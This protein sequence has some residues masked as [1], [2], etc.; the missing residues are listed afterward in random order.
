VVRGEDR[1]SL[2]PLWQLLPL[3]FVALYLV[4]F[5]TPP[6]RTSAPAPATPASAARSA[7][8]HGRLV[9]LLVDSLRPSNVSDASLMPTLHALA[10]SPGTVALQVRTCAS[11]F[12]LPCIQTIFSGRE[13]PMSAGLEQFSAYAGGGGSFIG[14]AA[15]AGLGVAL[16]GNE[17]LTTLYGRQARF[18]S[19]VVPLGLDALPADLAA[20]DQAARYLSNPVVD[21]LILHTAGTDHV[22][23]YDLPGSPGYRKH[24]SRVDGRLA[25]LL[26][27]LDLSRDALVVMGDHGH[28]RDGHHTRESV[29][30]FA[31]AGYG[32]LF[33]QIDVPPRVEQKDLLFLLA[34]P[35]R[36]AVPADYEGRYFAVKPGVEPDEALSSFLDVQREELGHSLGPAAVSARMEPDWQPGNERARRNLFIAMP[37]LLCFACWV[38]W[39]WRGLHARLSSPWPTLA[40][41]A[42]GL[43]LGAVLRSG[44]SPALLS[45][46][47]ALVLAWITWRQRALRLTVTVLLLLGAA[48]ATAWIEPQWRSFFHSRDEFHWGIP[49]FYVV[50]LGVGAL[51]AALRG[52]G[53]TWPSS[54]QLAAFIALPA[55]V[56]YYQFDENPLRAYLIPAALVLAVG[57]VRRRGRFADSRSVGPRL[58]E[59]RTRR[60]V[61]AA[62]AG[63]LLL[64]QNAGGWQW[65]PWV[66]MQLAAV[67]RAVAL[68][69]LA[70]L[71]G[72]LV[73]LLPA[74]RERLAMA[75]LA[76]VLAA[77]VLLFTGLDALRFTA[78]LVV[79]LF[80]AAWLGLLPRGDAGESAGLMIAAA[81][82]LIA[83][84]T[85]DGFV[86]EHVDFTFAL[87]YGPRNGGDGLVLLAV[88]LPVALK[89]AGPLLLLMAF[90]RLHAGAAESQRAA[91]FATLF[92]TFKLLGL[93]VQVLVGALDTGEKFFELA[94][95]HL[96]FVGCLL[97]VVGLWTVGLWG[98]ERLAAAL[99]RGTM[100]RG[101][102]RD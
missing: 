57:F 53:L 102:N 42:A 59:P 94:R 43:A 38:V 64:P 95:T 4:A 91:A 93:L 51:V 63:G 32:R 36:L 87:G 48:A 74:R 47:P 76:S 23:H 20:I 58:S 73:S 35:Q 86:I 67:P 19:S 25:T 45:V 101:S 72:W 44:L 37:P 61:A 41:G 79:V 75:A 77:Y 55:G 13:S 90:H 89:Y 83:L 65:H 96:V 8:P 21:V 22:T 31:G 71:G 16:V 5:S 50:M 92:L 80:G 1:L 40:A 15:A 34:F 81:A 3:A 24:F 26:S 30:L 28:D 9:V 66:A 98:V 33:R 69:A 70:A 49:L 88:A 6:G 82:V 7:T 85:C 27:A 14:M 60:A 56:Y 99:G 12:S 10:G 52:G 78:A 2:R 17:M 68:T 18:S 97:V 39:S 54:T 62:V 11:N 29:A 100:P 84:T 46:P